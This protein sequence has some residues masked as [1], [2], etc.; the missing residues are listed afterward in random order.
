MARDKWLNHL[1][2][3]PLFEN[4]DTKQL[5]Q[6]AAATVEI[7][8]EPGTV[9]LR[10]GEAGHEC[11]IIVSGSA[12]V[13]RNG[14]AIAT[15]GDGEVIGEL[16]PLT[17]GPRNATVTID[18][19]TDLLVLSQ[20]EFNGLLEQVPGFAVRILKNLAQRMVSR[21]EQESA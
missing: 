6:V 4:C 15:L 7:T 9:L 19:P 17:G 8:V 2:Q 5:Q 16:A 1:A 11:F 12:T 14:V 3:V 20:Q 21:E 13:S 18:A 10:E